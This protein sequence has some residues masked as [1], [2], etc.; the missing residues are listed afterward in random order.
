MEKSVETVRGFNKRNFHKMVQFYK[1]YK[2][3]QKVSILLTRF[4]VV[5]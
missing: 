4:K 5:Y 1:T 3:N 2:D